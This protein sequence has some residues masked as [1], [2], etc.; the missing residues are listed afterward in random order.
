LKPQALILGG[1]GFVGPHLA[2]QLADRYTVTAT[3][4]DHDIRDGKT[5]LGLVSRTAPDIVI[6]LAAITT[7]RESF[8]R[9]RETYDIGF[10]GLLNLLDAL[11][12]CG[13]RG[14][15]L[16][17]SSSEVYGFPT[18]E[19]LPLTEAAPFRPMS[20][21]AVAKAAGELLC[22]QWARQESFEIF[23]VRPFTHIGP[24]QSNRF[25]VAKFAQ[26]VAAI[27]AR[28]QEPI[29]RVGSLATARDFTDVRDVV[30]AYD[31]IIHRAEP[32]M[33]YNVCSGVQVT[34]RDIM[35]ELIRVTGIAIEIA[36]NPLEV[37]RSEQQRICGSHAAVSAV[38]GWQPEIPLIRTLKD[39]LAAA[40]IERSQ[41]K[42]SGI[43]PSAMERMWDA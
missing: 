15:V 31:L 6:N 9:P 4:R 36:E 10:L 12:S 5:V 3:G 33:V 16:Q 22:L 14:R 34:M 29:I 25:A 19:E 37:R 42:P 32:G 21:Y 20:P 40:V 43:S 11:K 39:V 24:G 30:R 13:F 27:M 35:N 1:T 26:Q 8:E 7:V 23:L 18:S 41:A 17:V 38:T 28:N 2:R